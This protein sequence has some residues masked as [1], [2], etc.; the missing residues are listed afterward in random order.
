MHHRLACLL[1]VILSIFIQPASSS[2]ASSEFP[3]YAAIEKNVEFWTL[4]YST[5]TSRQLVFHDADEL[6]RIY[7]VVNL[8]KGVRPFTRRAERIS[9]AEKA[10]V[11]KLL[12]RFGS[13][14]TPRNLDEQIIYNYFPPNSPA[15]VFSRA[16]RNIRTQVG[17]ADRFR[18]GI[19]RSGLYLPYIQRVFEEYD[20]PQGLAYLP[21][22]ESSFD[23]RAYSKFGAAGIWQFIRSTGRRFMRVGYTIDERRDPI[24]ATV[25]AAKLLRSNYEQI[26]Q[27]PLAITAY[28]HGLAGMRRAVRRVGSSDFGKIYQHYDGRRFGFASKN[29][30]ASFL[31][32]VEVA[33]NYKKYFGELKIMQPLKYQTFEVNRSIDLPTLIKHVGVEEEKFKF[34]NLGFRPAAYRYGKKIPKKYAIRL[35]IDENKDYATLM[36]SLPAPSKPKPG[37]DLGWVQVQHGDT[38]WEIS[39]QLGVP[40]HELRAINDLSSTPPACWAD[41]EGAKPLCKKSKTQAGDGG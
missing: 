6:M 37:T 34:L 1:I 23:Y 24:R 9:R 11:K 27:W 28:N 17:Q 41:F 33:T 36:A 7:G 8:P 14:E 35:P 22:V 4:I 38:L 5:H 32:A 31:A 13:G 10:R 26:K 25:A 40:M 18:D 30:Y 21:H 2:A 15:S 19:I 3:R 12:R 29:F 16:A 20:L 39:R